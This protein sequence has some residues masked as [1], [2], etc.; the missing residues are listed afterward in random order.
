MRLFREDH[1]RRSRETIKIATVE[2][3]A[4]NIRLMVNR[5]DAR[6]ASSCVDFKST[7]PEYSG[8]R[9]QQHFELGDQHIFN[10]RP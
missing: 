6:R 8:P 5:M 2:R 1:I 3:R 9:S 7:S 4:P 10:S